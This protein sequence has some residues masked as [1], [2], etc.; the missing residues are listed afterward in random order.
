MNDLAQLSQDRKLRRLRDVCIHSFISF[1][2]GAAFS[3]SR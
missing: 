2:H 1:S 3:R